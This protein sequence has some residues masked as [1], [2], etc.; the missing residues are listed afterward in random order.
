VAHAVVRGELEDQHAAKLRRRAQA[1]HLQDG[2]AAADPGTGRA[3]EAHVRVARKGLLLVGEL[4]E[5]LGEEF[6]DQHRDAHQD[7]RAEDDRDAQAQLGHAR[8]AHHRELVAARG[9]GLQ[10]KLRHRHERVLER[11]DQTVVAGAHVRLLADEDE[12]QPERHQY[13]HG[14]SHRA[15]QRAGDIA[16]E[17]VHARRRRAC[18]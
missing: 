11:L 3:G 9:E 16:V 18:R 2:V 7:H 5:G 1:L 13:R 8:H 14:Q 4:P 17:H 12:Q 10:R 15:E 6:P